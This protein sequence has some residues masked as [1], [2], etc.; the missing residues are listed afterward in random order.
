MISEEKAREV[1][2]RFLQGKFPGAKIDFDK[3]TLITRGST[4]LY[5]L[6][7]A[8]KPSSRSIFS[9]FSR[10]APYAFKIEIQALEGGVLNYELK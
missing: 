5:L 2:R 9:W 7:G 8:L 6:E 4:P 1:A 3:A 10:P